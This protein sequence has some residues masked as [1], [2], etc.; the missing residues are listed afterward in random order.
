MIPALAT[1]LMFQL[2]GEVIARALDL[3]L[4]GP[5]LGM[6]GL[7]AAFLLAPRLAEVVRPTAQGLLAHLSLLFVPAGVGV[8]AHF[9]VLSEQGPAIAVALVGSTVLAIA[10]GALV[11]AGVA[12]IIGS[13]DDG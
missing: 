7:V 11:F 6:I 13:R 3:P 5:V 10:V 1:I 2:A 8:V 12:R 4:P 9:G